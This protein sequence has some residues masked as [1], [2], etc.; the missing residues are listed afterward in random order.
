MIRPNV[1]ALNAQ[2]GALFDAA[3][4]VMRPDGDRS[5]AISQLRDTFPYASA[6]DVDQALREAAVQLVRP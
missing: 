4:E 5:A 1:Q 3:H 2:R 6:R